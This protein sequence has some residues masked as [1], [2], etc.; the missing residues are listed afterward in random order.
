MARFEVEIRVDLVL[1]APN[2]EA[3]ENAGAHATDRVRWAMTDMVANAVPVLYPR[4]VGQPTVSSD[5]WP[6]NEEVSGG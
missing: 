3:A 6:Q 2:L 4:I 5:T 1:E